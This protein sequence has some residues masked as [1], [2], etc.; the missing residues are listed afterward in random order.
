M[1][2][3]LVILL[4]GFVFVLAAVSGPAY[5]TSLDCDH[6]LKTYEELGCSAIPS[7]SADLCNAR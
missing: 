5:A 7:S 2:A 6:V 3:D 4:V 1:H